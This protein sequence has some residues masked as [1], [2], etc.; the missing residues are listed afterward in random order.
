M[1]RR[2]LTGFIRLFRPELP[3]A[4]GVCVVIGEIVA[5]GAFP[6]M[7]EAALG[8]A[9]GFFISGSALVSNDYFD[10]DVDRVNAPERPLP[11]G[12]V[13]PT[14]ALIW[15]A[16]AMALGLAA[17]LAVSPLTLVLAAV[18]G[19]VGVLY[20]WHFKQA[21]LL[22]N[23]MVAFS[24]GFTFVLGGLIAGRPFEGL[25]WFFALD[26]FCID[27]G[28]ELAGDAMDMEGDRQRGSRSLAIV[29]GKQTA[30]RLS[31]GI[32]AFVVLIS[33]LPYLLGWLGLPYLILILLADVVTVYATV[34]LLGSRT[35]EEGRGYMRMIYLTVL[36]AMMGYIGTEWFG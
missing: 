19:A 7:R 5:L 1:F 12:M 32:F 36:F 30:L 23:L 35:S 31:A 27:L 3:F 34:R 15:A 25:V 6:A 14:E 10:L 2:K 21:G 8:F 13:T 20:N 28:E 24:V 9:C 18:A 4:A 16:L 26:A 11:S 22:G 33:P 17:A 29:Y